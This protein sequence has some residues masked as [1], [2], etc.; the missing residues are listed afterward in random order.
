MSF[1]FRRVALVGFGL[2]GGSL[3]RALKALPDAPHLTGFSEDPEELRSGIE[4]GLLDD[5]PSLGSHFLHDLDLL[6]YATPPDVTLKLLA[7]HGGMVEKET[8]I[9]EVVSLNGPFLQEAEFLGLGDRCVASHPMAGG[10]GTGFGHSV[11]GLFQ[12]ARVW[13]SPGTAQEERV[14]QIERFWAAIGAEPERMEAQ[15]HDGLMAWVSHVPQVAANALAA[16]L[17]G[18]GVHPSA[19]GPGGLDATRLAR[20]SPGMWRQILEQGPETLQ[21]GL[22]AMEKT[23]ARLRGLLAEGRLEE[24]EAFMAET[25]DW[26]E[27]EE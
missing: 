1:P 12:G 21:D 27:V 25:R 22:E 10:T 9:T 5:A 4:A 24:V 26:L 8:T 15:A 18:A 2:M 19:L 7:V 11:D 14:R 6:I 13:V 23:L 16:T 17:K 20:S 3:A